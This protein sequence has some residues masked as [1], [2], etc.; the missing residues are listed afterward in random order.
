MI[1]LRKEVKTEM[2]KE[3]KGYVAGWAI[4]IPDRSRKPL[5]KAIIQKG[6]ERE[7]LSQALTDVGG[8]PGVDSGIFKW[9]EEQGR[10][11]HRLGVEQTVIYDL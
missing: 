4:I 10:P 6:I 3:I 1:C 5:R 9:V 11:A 2:V 7:N 8:S